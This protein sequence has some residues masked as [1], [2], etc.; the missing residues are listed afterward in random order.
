MTHQSE[1][2]F[3]ERFFANSFCSFCKNGSVSFMAKIHS[4]F[5]HLLHCLWKKTPLRSTVV[6][7]SARGAGG[8]GSIPDRITPKT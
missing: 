6:R 7:A 5:Q 1:T 4:R 3:S 8:R 2:H